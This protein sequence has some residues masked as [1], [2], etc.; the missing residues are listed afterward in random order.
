M[1]HKGTQSSTVIP[2]GG[3]V[4]MICVLCR[5]EG[6]EPF[7]HCLGSGMNLIMINQSPDKPEDQV[8]FAIEDV[9]WTCMYEQGKSKKKIFN[10][11]LMI[12]YVVAS[13]WG[14]LTLYNKQHS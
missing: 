1:I 13:D 9:F 14:T 5:D 2:N 3:E 11:S 4:L 6:V 7:P 12:I 8:Q 10:L